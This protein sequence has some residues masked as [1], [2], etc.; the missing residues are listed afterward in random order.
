MNLPLRFSFSKNFNK[1]FLAINRRASF[2]R[3]SVICGRAVA[4]YSNIC[5][6]GLCTEGLPISQHVFLGTP[7]FI[8]KLYQFAKTS[9]VP[10]MAR[11]KAISS[12]RPA[13]SEGAFISRDVITS[14]TFSDSSQPA[15]KNVINIIAVLSTVNNCSLKWR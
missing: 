14:W 11:A 1:S 13:R 9:D 4:K 5:F 3:L 6:V 15:V 10:S 12:R 8:A 2:R 7:S